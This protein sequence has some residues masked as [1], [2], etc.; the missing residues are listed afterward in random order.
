[1]TA[2]VSICLGSEM[3][4]RVKGGPFSL[5][6]RQ[7]KEQ[8]SANRIILG[9]INVPFR[10]KRVMMRA[11]APYF[12]STAAVIALIFAALFSSIGNKQTEVGGVKRIRE[13]KKLRDVGILGETGV[14]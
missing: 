9:E 8:R 2:D 6:F 12:P 1:M 7:V 4:P 14:I 3:I 13:M 5:C 10:E 11:D